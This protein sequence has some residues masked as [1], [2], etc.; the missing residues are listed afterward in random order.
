MIGATTR[1]LTFEWAVA[2]ANILARATGVRRRVR[3]CTCSIVEE[4][5]YTIMSADVA[6]L[7]AFDPYGKDFR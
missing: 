6:L 3:R 2:K 4:P 7:K 1:P 5:H